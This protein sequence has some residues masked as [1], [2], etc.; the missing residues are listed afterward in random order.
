[1]TKAKKIGL[2]L[3]IIGMCLPTA[4]L[5]FITEFRPVPEICLT[6]N[7]FQNMG[8]MIV[9]FGSETVS[10]LIAIPYRYLFSIGVILVSTGLGILVMTSGRLS[11]RKES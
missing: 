11:A 2:M 1:M 3:I 10:P 6:S 5:P 7:F 8:N 9:V 4:T